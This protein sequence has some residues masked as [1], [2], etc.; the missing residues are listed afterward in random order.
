MKL[1]KGRDNYMKQIIGVIFDIIVIAL[2]ATL[3]IRS[4]FSQ[5]WVWVYLNVTGLLVWTN[6]SKFIKLYK[7][8][9]K[10]QEVEDKIENINRLKDILNMGKDKK[11][12]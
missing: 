12:E 6:G 11:D 1:N 9:Q 10:R 2:F 4:S 7:L 3:A 8:Q 5:D